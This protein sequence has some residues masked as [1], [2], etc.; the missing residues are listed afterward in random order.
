MLLNLPNSN[1]QQQQKKN[2]LPFD[3]CAECS[4]CRYGYRK[5]E[6]HPHINLRNRQ[7]KGLYSQ[8]KSGKKVMI[9]VT[10]V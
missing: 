7:K 5:D 9:R 2:Q 3:G 6:T 8:C 1:T 10:A 4:L